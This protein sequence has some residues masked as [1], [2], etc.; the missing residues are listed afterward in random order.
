MKTLNIALNKNLPEA[1][2]LNQLCDLL[3]EELKHRHK[4]KNRRYA[5][6]RNTLINNNLFKSV[7]I[8]DKK[9]SAWSSNLRDKLNNRTFE[10]CYLGELYNCNSL[11]QLYT[12]IYKIQID[13]LA[14]LSGRAI[15]KQVLRGKNNVP[16]KTI[17]L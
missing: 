10:Q 11:K 7:K 12:V 13:R 14:G 4:N 6:V 2:Q 8:S 5:E 1:T 15:A 3:R 17:Q 16:C 9:P